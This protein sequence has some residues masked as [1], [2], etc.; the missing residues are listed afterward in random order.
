MQK[1]EN[2]PLP[3]YDSNSIRKIIENLPT[4]IGDEPPIDVELIAERLGFNLIPTASLRFLSSTD[5]YL[6]SRI[7][8]IAFDPDVV[9]VRIRFS[10]AHELG[11]YYL[12]DDI[13]KEVRFC[14]YTEWKETIKSIPGWFWGK[15]ETQANEFAAQLIV[16]RNLII[17]SFADFKSELELAKEHIPDEMDAIREY[18]SIPLARKF[19]VSQEVIKFRMI[20]ENLNPYDFI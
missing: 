5:A 4:S 2:I 18:L 14:D 10:I 7:K 13:I 19:D 9:P 20:N 11:H 8:E 15:V 17:R 6:S 3:N 16:P 1:F 12:H